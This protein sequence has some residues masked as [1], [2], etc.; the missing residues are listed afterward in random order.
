VSYQLPDLRYQ[1]KAVD[2]KVM[3]QNLSKDL[4][5]RPSVGIWYFRPGKIRFHEPFVPDAS[6]EERI[7]IAHKMASFGIKGIEAHYPDEINSDNVHL[8]KQLET[9][10]GIKV[11]AIPFSHCSGW[12]KNGE[13]IRGTMCDILARNGWVQ[14]SARK[15]LHAYVGFV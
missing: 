9:S 10:C 1:K 5:I 15:P 2:P 14:I 12:T 7:E 13:R 8:Y 11:A 6:I 4:E 3:L